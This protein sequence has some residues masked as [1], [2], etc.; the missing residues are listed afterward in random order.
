MLLM[1]V[2]RYDVYSSVVEVLLPGLSPATVS[3]LYESQ[4]VSFNVFP[5]KGHFKHLRNFLW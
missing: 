4:L 3:P 5:F 2:D 1:L